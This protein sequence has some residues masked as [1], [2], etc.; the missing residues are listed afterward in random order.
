M[1]SEI[2]AMPTATIILDA[3]LKD[4]L[5][6]LASQTGQK[7]DDFV[8]ALLRRIAEADVRFDR[9]VPV[10]RSRSGAPILTV[11]DVDRLDQGDKA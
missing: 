3:M 2:G 4:R 11:E 5:E 1:N 8:E 6:D 9:G 10:F 7:V